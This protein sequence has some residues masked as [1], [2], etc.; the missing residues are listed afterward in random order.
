[1]FCKSQG[2]RLVPGGCARV[3]VLSRQLKKE[4]VKPDGSIEKKRKKKQRERTKGRE[5]ENHLEMERPDEWF[6]HSCAFP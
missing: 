1:M 4:G 2:T 6:E 3:V 5:R